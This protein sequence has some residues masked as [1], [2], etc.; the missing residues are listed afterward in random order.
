VDLQSIDTKRAL[1][2]FQMLFLSTTA[3]LSSCTTVMA[4][5]ECATV[6]CRNMYTAYCY[7]V[8]LLL[9]HTCASVLFKV[10]CVLRSA[11]DSVSKKKKKE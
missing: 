4:R 3:V 1:L 8:H 10:C 11:L 9:L 6:V 5:C 2:R 7:G